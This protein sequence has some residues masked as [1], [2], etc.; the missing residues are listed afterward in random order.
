MNQGSSEYTV[1]NKSVK[2]TACCENLGDVKFGSLNIE[3]ENSRIYLVGELKI[4]LK[5]A[6]LLTK[7]VGKGNL[8]I[9]KMEKYGIRQIKVLLNLL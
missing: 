5:K 6:K 8:L 9:N 1:A 3:G 4:Y 2:V 7:E